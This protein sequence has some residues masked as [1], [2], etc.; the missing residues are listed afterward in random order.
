MPVIAP[1]TPAWAEVCDKVR[2]KW[3]PE[4]G[5]V[6]QMGDL[7]LFV[8]EPTGLVLLILV[9]AAGVLRIRWV[10]AIVVTLLVAIVALDV[11]AWVV[12]PSDVIKS[13]LSEGCVTMPVLRPIALFAAGFALAV[14]T[15][16]RARR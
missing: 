1:S 3:D 8:L 14:A 15:W 12:E 10:T 6:S 7:A 16:R 9:I 4:D 13:A 5:P 11:S 2:P